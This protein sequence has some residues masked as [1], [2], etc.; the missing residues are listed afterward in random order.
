MNNM[1][2]YTI[3]KTL[4]LSILK[5]QRVL[6]LS[7]HDKYLATDLLTNITGRVEV[8]KQRD[9]SFPV[10][11]TGLS[12]SDQPKCMTFIELPLLRNNQDIM[13]V[14]IQL[15]ERCFNTTLFYIEWHQWDEIL[16]SEDF[17]LL[18]AYIKLNANDVLKSFRILIVQDFYDTTDKSQILNEL[19]DAFKEIFKSGF[20]NNQVIY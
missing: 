17:Q 12:R 19:E 5:F 4:I 13:D 2:N 10:T 1:E 14:T 20:T 11:F 3:L 7:T 16:A 6:I 18:L 9:Y 8:S 15:R